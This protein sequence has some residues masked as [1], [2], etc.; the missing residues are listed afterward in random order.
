[1]KNNFQ[2]PEFRQLLEN[3]FTLLKPSRNRKD[4]FTAEL[5]LRGYSDIA[6]HIADLLKVCIMAMD[7]D[8][9]HAASSAIPEPN[10]NILGVLEMTLALLPY[11]EFELLDILHRGLL[12]AEEDAV[13]MGEPLYNYSVVRVL[14]S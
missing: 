4:T 13:P 10:V 11:N 5:R 7:A 8:N 1:M 6:Y 2:N 9:S 14:G 12:E 3:H